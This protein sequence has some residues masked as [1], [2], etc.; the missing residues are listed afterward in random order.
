MEESIS[1][2]SYVDGTAQ[3]H[4]DNAV[5]TDISQY[6]PPRH[7]AEPTANTING[8]DSRSEYSSTDRASQFNSNNAV[9]TDIGRDLGAPTVNITNGENSCTKFSDLIKEHQ[10]ATASFG[11]NS[12]NSSISGLV[13]SNNCQNSTV[14]DNAELTGS[15]FVN[16]KQSDTSSDIVLESNKYN[17][18]HLESNKYNYSHLESNKYNYSHLED[19]LNTDH[20]EA[21]KDDLNTHHIEAEKDKRS[22]IS[23]KNKERYSKWLHWCEKVSHVIKQLLREVHGGVWQTR[24]LHIEHV[25]SYAPHV[26]HIVLD[27][28]CIPFSEDNLTDIK[29]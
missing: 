12:Q 9:D 4:S 26:D 20:I 25:K 13:M 27:L 1:E 11:L 7:C 14:E 19:D 15:K 24:I 23:V 22:A 3:Y 5:D 16:L 17:Y 2:C 28:K 6:L 10:P 21:E 8:Q 29:P 18:S